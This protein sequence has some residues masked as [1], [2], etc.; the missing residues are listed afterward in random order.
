MSLWLV[1][2]NHRRI[3]AVTAFWVVTVSSGEEWVTVGESRA[4]KDLSIYPLLLGKNTLPPLYCPNA[5]LRGDSFSERFT[6]VHYSA[7]N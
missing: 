4:V 2:K 7:V 3:K 6:L 1:E 5:R